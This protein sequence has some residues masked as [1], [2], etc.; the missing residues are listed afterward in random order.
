MLSA[1]RILDLC[2]ERGALAGRILADLG[3]EVIRIEP[4]EGDP[5][6]ARGPQG[7]SSQGAEGGLAWLVTQAGKRGIALDLAGTPADRA[8]FLALAATA[9]AVIET[10]DPGALEAIGLDRD[11]VQAALPPEHPGLVWCS[12]TPFGRTGPFA[13]HAGHDLV[14]VAMG[15]NASMTGD[16]DRPPLRCSLPTAY[17]HG[18]PEA[19]IGLLLALLGRPALGRGQHVDV[20]LQET[21]LGTLLSGAGQVASGGPVRTRSGA[22]TGRTREIWRCRDGYVSYGLRGGPA[23]AGG[24]RA[25][26]DYMAECGMAPAWLRA[27]DWASYSPLTLSDDELERLEA[28]FAAFFETKTMRTLYEEAIERRILLAPC[29]DAREILAQP[30][31]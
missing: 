8:T 16:P 19:V 24:L 23:R 1:Y 28:V 15:G 5:L 20:S 4:R 30:Q 10:A 27:I 25:T 7:P 13:G 18:G 31:L 17:M 3:A 9:D 2:D 26:V 14:C 11:S 21:Q 29:N 22:R 6:R 12:I